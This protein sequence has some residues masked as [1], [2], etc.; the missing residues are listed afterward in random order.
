MPIP[1]F[2]YKFSSIIAWN[3]CLKSC[4]GIDRA[5]ILKHISCSIF[6]SIPSMSLSAFPEPSIRCSAY[7]FKKIIDLRLC[8][9]C[10]RF[11][12]FGNF[13]SRSFLVEKWCHHSQKNIIRL[14]EV[15][16]AC[17]TSIFHD[18]GKDSSF[19]LITF[20]SKFTT[21]HRVSHSIR[22][23]MI[24]IRFYAKFAVLCAI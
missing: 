5:L 24:K 7:D 21:K 11:S 1:Q 10:S 15:H 14:R 17:P 23:S 13:E 22:I 16:C 20:L 6:Q 4:V 9:S 19:I 3:Q 12:L 8:T 18:L 2:H